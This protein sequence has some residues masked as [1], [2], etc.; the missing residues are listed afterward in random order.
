MGRFG[1][2]YFICTLS[3][4]FN[5]PS[6]FYICIFVSIFFPFKAL[7][8]IHD[9][10]APILVIVHQNPLDQLMIQHVFIQSKFAPKALLPT[11]KAFLVFQK[12]AFLELLV[13]FAKACSNFTICAPQRFSWLEN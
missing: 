6:N 12:L 10:I 5:Y 2:C 8:T 9:L 11:E 7:T 13:L 1:L 3:T 4:S